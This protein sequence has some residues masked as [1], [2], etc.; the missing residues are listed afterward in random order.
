MSTSN[1]ERMDAQQGLDDM[2]GALEDIS[3]NKAKQ[4]HATDVGVV[5]G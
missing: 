1:K 2:L 3:R 4:C 5:L